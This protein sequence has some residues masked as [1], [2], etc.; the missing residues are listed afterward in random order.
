MDE[1]ERR[2]RRA[3]AARARP[4][5]PAVRA[6][7]AAAKRARRLADPETHESEILPFPNEEKEFE[8]PESEFGE[9]LAKYREADKD[10]ASVEGESSKES[11]SSAAG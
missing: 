10:K 4:Q 1:A 8:L 2:A 3:A 7:E 9:V 6:R 5:D 11:Q